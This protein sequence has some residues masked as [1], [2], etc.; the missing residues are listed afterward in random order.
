MIIRLDISDTIKANFPV[1]ETIKWLPHGNYTLEIKKVRQSRSNSQNA[2]FHWVIVPYIAERMGEIAKWMPWTP[3]WLEN[4]KEALI[5][6]YL[7]NEV[8]KN[9]LDKRRKIKV[10]KRTSDCDTA[11]FK[12]MIDKILHDFPEIPPPDGDFRRM[13][14]Y[15]QDTYHL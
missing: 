11:E 3:E 13:M 7:P 15:Y 6:K 4:A 1:S 8:K 12:E 14:E 10:Q 9:P 2:Y 5:N